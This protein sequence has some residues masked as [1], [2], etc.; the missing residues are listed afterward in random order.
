MIG[1]LRSKLQG[2]TA[3]SL[4][5]A[6]SRL[7][8]HRAHILDLVSPTPGRV[9]FGRAATIRYVAYR[10]DRFD[11]AA[12]GFARSFYEAV[13]GDF[14]ETVLVLDS[15]GHH[16]TSIGGGVKLSRLHNHGVAGLVTDARIRDFDELA[17][18]SPAFYCSGEA[19]Q[20]GSHML[21]PVAV[22]VPVSL[23]GTTIVPGDFVYADR[24]GAV[25]I[26]APHIDRVLELARD[27]DANDQSFLQAIRAE[28][29]RAIPR[30]GRAEL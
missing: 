29:R 16:D 3:A 17:R 23:R 1:A 7:C 21:M 28:T 19:V 6:V 26:P 4:A 22:N 30:R 10:E 9:L 14:R 12:A 25:V 27:I 2:L 18:Y 11:E 13:T 24:A 8:S 20:A 15:S 5:D